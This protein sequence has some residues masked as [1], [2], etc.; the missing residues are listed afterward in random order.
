MVAH[1]THA[2]LQ[3]EQL[4]V[5]FLDINCSSRCDVVSEYRDDSWQSV[6]ALVE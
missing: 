2:L 3:L 5:D 6:R 1:R 4:L